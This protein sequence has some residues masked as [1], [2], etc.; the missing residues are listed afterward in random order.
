MKIDLHPHN[1]PN[2][3]KKSGL[4]KRFWTTWILQWNP[5]SIPKCSSFYLHSLK[6]T[7]SPE[8][9]RPSPKKK[10]IFPT[11]LVSGGNLLLL[12]G[13]GEGYPYWSSILLLWF[14]EKSSSLAPPPGARKVRL[15][16]HVVRVPVSV[17]VLRCL[18][19]SEA[20]SPLRKVATKCPMEIPMGNCVIFLFRKPIWIDSLHDN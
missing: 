17:A 19:L 9:T 15:P 2:L 3:T 18:N 5:Y 1:A 6:P 13:R 8:K 11:I 12:A 20:K 16:L 10:L 14:R 4:K 7:Y